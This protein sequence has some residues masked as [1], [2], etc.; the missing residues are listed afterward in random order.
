MRRK[1]SVLLIASFT[2]GLGVLRAQQAVPRN[3]QLQAGRG[4][5][6]DG[7]TMA[8]DPASSFWNTIG[9][10]VK[11]NADNIWSS[12]QTFQVL[13][14][15]GSA[16]AGG[17][18]ITN[19]ANGSNSTDLVTIQQLEGSTNGFGLNSGGLGFQAAQGIST[20]SGAAIGPYCTV[21]IGAAIGYGNLADKGASL[22]DG[23]GTVHGA[24]IGWGCNSSNGVAIGVNCYT[25]HGVSLGTNAWS[26]GDGIQLGTGS[27][28][29]A[30]TMQ[31]YSFP[32]LDVSGNIPVERLQV[33]GD[34]RYLGTNV[35]HS[36]TSNIVWSAISLIGQYDT[37]VVLLSGAN[38]SSY[39]PPPYIS[40]ADSGAIY[41]VECIS[42]GF[43][44]V[45]RMAV[46]AVGVVT[47]T[48]HVVKVGY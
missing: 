36:V 43:V 40:P 15:S 37:N 5:T 32:L 39:I 4:L 17:F 42:N 14:L 2:L 1:L 12:N 46:V 23:N 8:V 45:Y 20:Y 7:S 35:T 11:T 34:A 10:G 6:S 48:V 29:V 47:N 30:S 41:S 21:N 9:G 18:S 28:G 38:S 25:Q 26:T 27:N 22:G 19:A 16:N 3:M 44:S 13:T 31:A 24:A 33:A